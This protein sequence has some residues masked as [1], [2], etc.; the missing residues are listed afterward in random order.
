MPA[1]FQAVYGLTANIGKA[2]FPTTG[3]VKSDGSSGASGIGTDMSL[4]WT[5]G[6]NGSFLEKIRLS[7]V[8]TVAATATAATVLRIYL[9]TVNTGVTANTNTVLLQEIGAAA[10]TAAHS[11]NATFFFEVPFSIKV[12]TAYYVLISTHTA[13]ATNTNWE[14]IA[15]GMD[16]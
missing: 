14:A 10:Q 12:P 3:L 16:F 15:L 6:A 7:P 2:L 4:L 13:P 8:A 1:N 9:S 5:A 11:T